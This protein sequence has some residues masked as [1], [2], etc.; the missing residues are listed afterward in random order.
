MV[1]DLDNVVREAVQS[2]LPIGELSIRS[3]PHGVGS[4][5]SGLS[6]EAREASGLDGLA[7]QLLEKASQGRLAT[8]EA[9]DHLGR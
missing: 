6:L 3:W 4:S 1:V 9:L 5:R 8:R 2:C 7:C